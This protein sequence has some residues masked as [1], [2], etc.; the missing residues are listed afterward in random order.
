MRLFDFKLFIRN[1]LQ[2]RLYS[3][4]TVGGFAVSL[5]F[6]IFLGM[7]IRQELLVDEFHTKKE[8]IFRIAG[9]NGAT[10][11]ALVGGKLKNAFPEIEEYTRL[12]E[13][14]NYGEGNDGKKM[15]VRMLFTDTSF[16]KMFDFPLL[17]GRPFKTRKELVIS[18][19]FAHKMFGEESPLG[20][21]L[22]L[23]GETGWIIVGIMADFPSYTH[24]NQEEVIADFNNLSS[25]WIS[26]D[27]SASF[28][29]YLLEKPESDLTAKLPEMHAFLK[30]DF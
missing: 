16:W 3:A 8:R 6:V 25:N 28:G 17:K 27:N 15:S 13:C 23:E 7:Y 11:G 19:S 29:V 9:E 5:T 14:N 4:I 12:Y 2:N 1:L 24:F 26:K 10:W 30:K 21:D 18:N 22:K 20:K